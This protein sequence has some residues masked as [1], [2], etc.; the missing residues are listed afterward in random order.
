MD[1]A[2]R[3]NFVD[4][5]VQRVESF[6]RWRSDDEYFSS[7]MSKKFGSDFAKNDGRL[8]FSKKQV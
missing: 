5:G 2:K 1:V 7:I 6:V 8:D 4:K 3:A